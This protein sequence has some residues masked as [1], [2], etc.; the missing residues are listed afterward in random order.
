ML[1]EFI[2]Y[3]LNISICNS[4]F[5]NYNVNPYFKTHKNT[6][7]HNKIFCYYSL[8]IVPVKWVPMFNTGNI[9]TN[10]TRLTGKSLSDK[11]LF[12][13]NLVESEVK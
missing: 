5:I 3:L 13:L 12:E 7:L 2:I 10:N 1:K 6:I 9:P 11:S 8:S 4:Y